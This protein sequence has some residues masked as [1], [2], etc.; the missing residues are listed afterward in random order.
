[1]TLVT[2]CLFKVAQLCS[3][4]DENEN[5][6]QIHANVP[7]LYCYRYIYRTTGKLFKQLKKQSL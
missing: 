6:L 3:I 4:N 5:D 2:A 7:V 1:V